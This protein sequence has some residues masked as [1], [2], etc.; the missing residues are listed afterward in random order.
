M[1]ATASVPDPVALLDR[2][3]ERTK[4]NPAKFAQAAGV[5]PSIVTRA[6][7]GERRPGLD[8]AIKIERESGGDVPVQAGEHFRFV[9]RKR[10][11]RSVRR[12]T[13][14]PSEDED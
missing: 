6:L 3:L 9:K 14:V 12:P 1:G 13:L 2:H 4:R 11:P 10:R 7:L 8:V 5:H